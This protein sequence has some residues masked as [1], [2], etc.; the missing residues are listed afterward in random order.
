MLKTSRE[1]VCPLD[2]EQGMKNKCCC[3]S[4]PESAEPLGLVAVRQAD[5]YRAKGVSSPEKKAC[6]EGG[7][8]QT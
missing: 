2:A 7:E 3:Y 5:C 6:Q 1:C 8:G 4:Q